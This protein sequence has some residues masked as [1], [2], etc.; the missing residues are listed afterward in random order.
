MSI[1]N[2]FKKE[3]GSDKATNRRQT[4]TGKK[5][6]ALAVA[7]PAGKIAATKPAAAEKEQPATGRTAKDAVAPEVLGVLSKSIITEKSAL[8]GSQNQ[9]VFAVAK[10]ANKLQVAQAIFSRYGVKPL[11]VN[12]LNNSGKAVRYGRTR[13][14]GK[15][16]KKAVV[17]LPAGQ[18]IEIHEGV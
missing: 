16:W 10:N 1:F 11:A 12:I 17:T 3:N 8:L 15:D 4:A 7:K 2:R 13:G 14:R 9:Y 5:T 18:S 6:A